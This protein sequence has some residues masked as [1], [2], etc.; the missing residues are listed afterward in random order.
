M[1]L[2]LPPSETKSSGGAGPP[3]ALDRLGFPELTDVRRALVTALGD[4]AADPERC[5]KAL[6]LSANQDAE[7]TRN[8]RLLTSPTMPAIARYS[9]VLYDALDVASLSA[10]ARRR[11]AT[12]VVLCSALFGA[13]RPDDPIPAYRLSAGSALDGLGALTALWRPALAQT[14]AQT[15]PVIDLRSGAY[16][17]LAPLPAAVAVRVICADGRT[18]SHHN[19]AA[20]GQLVRVFLTAPRQPRTV[21][22]LIAAATATGMTVRQTRPRELEILA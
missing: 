10:A 22:A 15:S 4:L 16:A 12:T 20:K 3:L 11:A 5:R 18:I 2:L 6:G 9:G 7:I 14:L 13:L 8:A 17:A 1:L 21:R 19:K